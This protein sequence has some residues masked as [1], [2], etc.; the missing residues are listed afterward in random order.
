MFVALKSISEYKRYNSYAEIS[1]LIEKPNIQRNII[2]KQIDSMKLYTKSCLDKGVEP[3][4][5][6]V[7]IVKVSSYPK[8]FIVDGQHRI[9]VIESFYNENIHIPIHAMIHSAE[10]YEEMEDIFRI[11]NLG[12]PVPEFMTIKAK[13]DIGKKQN[14]LKNIATWL[15]KIPTFRYKNANRPY[16]SIINF[17]DNFLKSKLYT[18]VETQEEFEKVLNLLNSEA[19]Y[20][21]LSLDDKG[22]KRAGIT[23]N[24]LKVWGDSKVYIGYDAT[25]PYLSPDY[26]ITRFK[27][28][29]NKN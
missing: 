26:D 29:L 5:G 16:V 22:K 11:R 4:F 23:A 17:L 12:V 6:S 9:S 8:M 2:S 18:I 24:M 28:L 1:S 27:T 13:D 19:Y 20:Y 21:V 10:T 14:L 15:E 25:Y 3:V 7:D